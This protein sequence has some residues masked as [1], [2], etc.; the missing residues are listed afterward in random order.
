MEKARALFADKVEVDLV[1]GPPMDEDRVQ[2][3]LVAVSELGKLGDGQILPAVACWGVSEVFRLVAEKEVSPSFG[4]TTTAANLATLIK[5]AFKRPGK[6]SQDGAAFIL[7]IEG[8]HA[9]TFEGGFRCLPG[10]PSKGHGKVLDIFGWYLREFL[11]SR[12]GLLKPWRRPDSDP[13]RLRKDIP[14]CSPL[15]AAIAFGEKEVFEMLVA[16]EPGF[17]VEEL[18]GTPDSTPLGVAFRCGDLHFAER[19]F[20]LGVRASRRCERWGP[21]NELMRAGCGQ[22]VIFWFLQSTNTPD[23]CKEGAPPS[24]ELKNARFAVIRHCVELEPSTVSELSGLINLTADDLR[25]VDFMYYAVSADSPEL[26]KLALEHGGHFT[27]STRSSLSDGRRSA[28]KFTTF[29]TATLFVSDGTFEYLLSQGLLADWRSRYPE[30]GQQDAV[31]AFEA[32]ASKA[33]H[34]YDKPEGQA[35][36]RRLE[37]ILSA[38]FNRIHNSKGHNFLVERFFLENHSGK[39]PKEEK[40]VMKVLRLLHS[41]GCDLYNCDTRSVYGGAHLPV[42]G[43]LLGFTEMIDFGLSMPGVGIDDVCTVERSASEGP[44]KPP[45]KVTAL[46]MALEHTKLVASRH[47]LNKGARMAIESFTAEEQP[48]NRL[49]TPDHDDFVFELLSLALSKQPDCLASKYF[50]KG[51]LAHPLHLAIFYNSAAR[52]ELILASKNPYLE[53][54]VNYLGKIPNGTPGKTE[55]ATAAQVAARVHYWHFLPPFLRH[56]KTRVT[57]EGIAALMKASGLFGARYVPYP[58]VEE[59]VEKYCK[60]RAIRALVKAVAKREREELAREQE[61]SG[62][63]AAASGLPSNAFELPG[64]KVLTEK[65][66]KAKAKK[67]EQKKKAK[68]KKRAA[69]AAAAG[70]GA[71]APAEDS[72]DSSGTD[73]E[74]KG[75]DEE[76]RMLARAPTFDLEKERAARKAAKEMQEKEEETKKKDQESK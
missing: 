14:Y 66:E 72:D 38:G 29:L 56:T 42:F 16:C 20:S 65:E 25:E 44:G 13:W 15:S 71:E 51:D 26:I 55:I 69:A 12:C 49:V 41:H 3:F 59:S 7:A 73:E 75:L 48:I 63:K 22:P 60:D 17:D 47:L 53:E 68:A 35:A 52:L 11:P 74:E 27:T 4:Q 31:L 18:M 34:L 76:G 43:A 39:L 30:D 57:K 10:K 33:L 8:L 62:S 50:S 37:M 61:S 5:A 36:W 40:E 28:T 64:P 6:P 32:V 2:G 67:R 54:A 58:S 70:A 21:N 1:A 45:L 23:I 46:C 9:V 19:L 24:A